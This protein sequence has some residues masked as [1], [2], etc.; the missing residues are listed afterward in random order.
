MEQMQFHIPQCIIQNRDVH[1]SVLND[2]LWDM[3][4]MQFHIPQ[5]I[6]QNRDVHISVLSGAFWDMEQMHYGTCEIG[7]ICW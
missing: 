1:I 6:I 4:Q 2:A 5:C 3:E 7:V